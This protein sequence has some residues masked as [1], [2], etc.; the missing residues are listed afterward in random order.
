MDVLPGYW[1]AVVLYAAGHIGALRMTLGQVATPGKKKLPALLLRCSD[2]SKASVWDVKPPGQF[3]RAWHRRF[4]WPEDMQEGWK[5]STQVSSKAAA[6]TCANGVM[7]NDAPCR[8]VAHPQ[9]GM[10]RLRRG[11][12]CRKRSSGPT[13]GP[14][15]QAQAMAAAGL[16][17]AR[18]AC[19][20]SP[21]VAT[22]RLICSGGTVTKARRNVLVRG[23]FA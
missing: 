9:P 12:L 23:S 4:R 20:T 5:A 18:A 3:A 13:S 19:T 15:R 1:C 21:R 14:A 16:R 10:S 8:T 22:P 7:Q 17:A 11:P 2:L 6:Q